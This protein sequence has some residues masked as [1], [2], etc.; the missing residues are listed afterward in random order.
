[1]RNLINETGEQVDIKREK[2]AKLRNTFGFFY[3]NYSQSH[4][5]L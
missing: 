1:M 5:N 3:N 4:E 2:K